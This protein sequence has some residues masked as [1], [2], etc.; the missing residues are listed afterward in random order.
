[1]SNGPGSRGFRFDF[2][3]RLASGVL[4]TDGA[5][6][7]LLGEHG[8]GFRHPYDRANLTHA[9]LVERLHGEYVRAGAQL[10][11]T[12]T[13]SANRVKLSEYKLDER[14]AE[15]NREGARLARRAADNEANGR[16]RV[17]VLGAVGPL[18]RPLSP[19]GSITEDE[20]QGV[21]REQVEALLEGGVDAVL[22]ETFTDLRELRL[23]FEVTREFGVPVLAYKTFVEDGETLA[24]GLPVRVAKELSGWGVDVVGSNCTVGPQRMVGI[25]EQMS[26][27]IGPVAA[28]PNPGLPQLINGEIHYRRDVG[29]FTEYGVKL[30]EAGA[31]LIGGCCGTTPEHIKSLAD[32]LRDFDASGAAARQAVRNVSVKTRDTGEGP[33]DIFTEEEARP[34]SEFARRLMDGE[35]ATT[36]EVDLPRGNDITEVIEA[37]RRLK[38]R[39]V[40]AIDI[41][42]GARAR[43]RMGPVA[44]GRIVQDE[45]GI[46]VVAHMCCRDRNTIGLQSDLLSASALGVMNILAIT[47]DPP[48]IGDYPE[49]TGV[50]DTDAIGLVHIL[51]E[52]NRGRD[53]AGNSIGRAPGFL[54]GA[55]FNPTADDLPAEVEKVRRK[56]E[57]GAHA[58][59][60][61]PV[62]EIEDLRRAQEALAAADLAEIKVLLGLMPLRSARQAEFLHHEVPGINI[63]KRVREGL[64]KL[65]PEDAP[66]FGVEV[67]QELLVAAKDSVAGAYIMPP[68]SAPDLA[69]DV[70]EALGTPVR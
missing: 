51:S 44:V 64:A 50:F 10:I 53:L 58:Y 54:I 22:L 3:E 13:F 18:G 27:E 14:V 49:A 25:V 38:E 43:L 30:A 57:A 24:A 52:M 41:S 20:A 62:F 48:L 19:I 40:N 66:K 9:E 7:T 68:A 33:S 2:A 59:W 61:Q 34:A 28:L 8:V 1:M 55:A 11:E 17:P 15:I 45:V 56:H 47:G 26:D 31:R 23:A 32:A 65:P 70:V 42:D 36:V 35:F 5:M 6:G 4:V 12:N 60:S 16:E 69:G 46:E 39:G 67:A 37:S 21:F 63:P 29:H